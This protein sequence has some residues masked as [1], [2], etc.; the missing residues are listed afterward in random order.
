MG[1]VPANVIATSI[2][3][4]FTFTVNWLVVF[5]PGDPELATR[6]VKFVI[7]TATSA[8]VLQNLVIHALSRVWLGPTRLGVKLTRHLAAA[9]AWDDDVIERNIVK[10]AAVVGGLLWN[11][12]W[13]KHF[14]YAE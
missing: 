9:Q 12:F 13:Y 7:V 5:R 2:A 4:I 10:V 3:M 6:A 11:F 14:V 1:R 8:Y